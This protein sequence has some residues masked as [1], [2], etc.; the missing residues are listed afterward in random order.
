MS[1]TSNK[2][3]EFFADQFVR[4]SIAVTEA[5]EHIALYHAVD[6]D[7]PKDSY[8]VFLIMRS[9]LDML[10]EVS[11]LLRCAHCALSGSDI[12]LPSSARIQ[13]SF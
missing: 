5:I 8:E 7:L 6:F 10:T 13:G 3:H 12:S 11:E 9:D 4:D 2:T 1:Q